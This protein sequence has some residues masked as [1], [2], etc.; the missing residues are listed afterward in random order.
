MIIGG[1]KFMR[2]FILAI[3]SLTCAA[4]MTFPGGPDSSSSNTFTAP[5]PI[6]QPNI[7]VIQANPNADWSFGFD[8]LR[9]ID[10]NDVLGDSIRA[11]NLKPMIDVNA[12][13]E[14]KTIMTHGPGH[15]T[16]IEYF[17][18]QGRA[19]LWYPG[20]SRVV[21]G[22]WALKMP[23]DRYE[24]CFNYDTPSRN[25]VTLSTSRKWKCRDLA[26]FTQ[27]TKETRL[28]DI[29]DL[30]SKEVPFPLTYRK[31]TLDAVLA[32][33][34]GTSE[35]RNRRRLQSLGYLARKYQSSRRLFKSKGKPDNKW[36]AIALLL[37]LSK[38]N[39]APSMYQLGRL[40][41]TG[42]N[43]VK[44]IVEAA[45]WFDLAAYYSLPVDRKLSI[46]AGNGRQKIAAQ[47]SRDELVAAK[48][49][50]QA[51]IQSHGKRL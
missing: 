29:F 50:S 25:P 14:D 13:F 31:T 48:T 35:P 10:D 24:L 38:E 36:R 9:A 5:A 47:L 28:S 2:F 11:I 12:L 46:I 40:S 49:R 27:H 16:Q 4:C 51:W 33:E 26:S 30:A 21:T 15:G 20:N 7:A 19:Y 39:H 23:K 8:E 17:D 18:E 6:F 45:K 43:I 1:V 41:R 44:N 32:N 37:E 34:P 42:K 3:T 22:D